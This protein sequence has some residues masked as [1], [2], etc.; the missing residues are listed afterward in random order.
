MKNILKSTVALPFKFLK[1]IM[2]M[3][4]AV[5]N[6]ILKLFGHPGLATGGEHSA[7]IQDETTAMKQ[8]EMSQKN[9][10]VDKPTLEQARKIVSDQTL[11]LVKK[12][13]TSKERN[14]TDIATLSKTMKI[15]VSGLSAD[16]MA[17]LAKMTDDQ[18]RL[19]I[20]DDLLALKQR[21][22]QVMKHEPVKTT[23]S[24]NEDEPAKNDKKSK[25]KRRIQQSKMNAMPAPKLALS[26]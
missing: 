22:T 6:T 1:G 20:S 10:L 21:Q 19:Q 4:K 5:L 24:S 8:D 25:L 16:K 2:D 17:A 3:M 7:K 23:S 14:L 15:Y 12:Y 26:M 11:N 18:M 9:E 13:V